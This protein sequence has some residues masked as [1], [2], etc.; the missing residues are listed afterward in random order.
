MRTFE[1][2]LTVTSLN[3]NTDI[4]ILIESIQSFVYDSLE[5]GEELEDV[6]GQELNPKIYSSNDE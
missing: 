4:D 5:E 3:D 1:I 6:V 2:K